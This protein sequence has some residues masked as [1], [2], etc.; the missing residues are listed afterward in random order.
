MSLP[1][2]R[3]NCR[4]FAKL[5]SHAIRGRFYTSICTKCQFFFEL[6][7]YS[8]H[9]D[10]FWLI[11]H[12]KSNGPHM[13]RKRLTQAERRTQITEVAMTLFA[14]K[15]FTGTTTRAIARAADVSEAI[16]FRHFATKED[17]YNAIIT[18]TVEKRSEQWDRDTT[19]PPD[20]RNIEH[21]L[22]DFAQT[23]V[24]RNRRD[25][26]FIRLMMY[27]AL[28]DHKFREK[29]FAIYSNPHM[30]SIRQAIQTGVDQGMFCA[31]DPLESLRSFFYALLQY[32]ISRFIARNK[33]D[34]PERDDAMIE[35]L[36]TIFVRGLRMDE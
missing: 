31:V 2:P 36:V 14:T 19:P 5:H 29:F 25:S 23:F 28:E 10:I 8:F 24:N 30:R 22:R 21:L 12:L 13:P 20:P 35:N 26:T 9:D 6:D 32:C 15:G 16:I 34:T 17:L 18:Y 11:I 4:S 7:N 3:L 27:S 1:Q 33:I